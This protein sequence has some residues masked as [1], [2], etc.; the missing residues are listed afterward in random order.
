[1]AN[2][3]RRRRGG[4]RWLSAPGRS[5]TAARHRLHFRTEHGGVTWNE[6]QE[7]TS[8][9]DR[10]DSYV[11]CIAVS[12]RS[13]DQLAVYKASQIHTRIAFDFS[14]L[15]VTPSPRPTHS[16]MPANYSTKKPVQ[17]IVGPSRHSSLRQ[18]VDGTTE[19]LLLNGFSW[20]DRRFPAASPATRHRPRPVSSSSPVMLNHFLLGSKLN[21]DI[22][23]NW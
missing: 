17:C 9:V 6:L 10:V 14:W 2:P 1:M 16:T 8:Y 3:P 20:P 22:V 21:V 11:L 5:G 7:D 15:R 4:L 23:H 12:N 18:G 19:E 13:E